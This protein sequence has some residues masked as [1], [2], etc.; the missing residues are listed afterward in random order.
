MRGAAWLTGERCRVLGVACQTCPQAAAL[1]RPLGP[2][3]ATKRRS[4]SAGSQRARDTI[5]EA[6]GV[7]RSDRVVL[8][9]SETPAADPGR[10]HPPARRAITP[11]TLAG[12]LG[13]ATG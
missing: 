11:P 1:T 13:G 12:H 8:S 5:R 3:C 4:R 6:A 10:G 2:R 9:R 7:A